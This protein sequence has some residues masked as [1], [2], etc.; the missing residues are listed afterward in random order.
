MVVVDGEPGLGKTRT[1]RRL[2]TMTGSLY[3]R[4]QK[5]WD[6]DWFM[7][8]A[9]TEL[10]VRDP[11]R[12]RRG[13]FDLVVE[14]ARKK[15]SDAAAAGLVWC[16]LVDECD[17]VSRNPQVM[18]GIRSLSDL[19]EIPTVLV[20]MGTL[21]DHLR[22]YQQIGSRVGSNKVEFQR[23]T[24]EDATA[25]VR[26]L[27]EVS[28]ADDLIRFIHQVSKGYSREIVEAVKLVERFGFRI[29]PGPQGVTM[30]D[31]AG[32]PIMTNRDTTLPI[33]VPEA[34]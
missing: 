21:R 19:L 13:R 18:E 34:A 20:G 31:M 11:V 24:L 29:E 14:I 3:L 4:A 26:G 2:V 27:C 6:Y 9:L 32:Q 1:M 28:V 25:L 23:A 12:G 16:L 30:A 15:I 5:G 7:H 22:R 8:A 17:M 10:G 33:L